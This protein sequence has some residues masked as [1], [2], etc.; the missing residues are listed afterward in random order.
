MA[1]LDQYGD[2]GAVEAVQGAWEYVKVA[3]VMGHSEES[4]KTLGSRFCQTHGIKSL[5]KGTSGYNAYPKC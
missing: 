3:R 4:V 5:N 2:E 1:L